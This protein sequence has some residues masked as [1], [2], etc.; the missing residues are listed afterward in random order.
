[1][2]EDVVAG[3]EQP[4][5]P[6]SPELIGTITG[7]EPSVL[8]T[9]HLRRIKRLLKDMVSGCIIIVVDGGT[10]ESVYQ[11]QQYKIGPAE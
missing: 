4:T 1:M 3:G 9:G 8:K 7:I 10:V 5:L 11:V 2:D 6:L